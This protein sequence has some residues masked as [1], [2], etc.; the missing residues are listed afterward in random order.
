MEGRNVTRNRAS[1]KKAGATFE[2]IVADY[3][4]EHVDDRIDRRVRS[5]AKDKGDIAGVRFHGLRIVLEVKNHVR[6]DLAGWYAEA[7][8][9]AE[10]DGAL[11][12]AVIS[13]R[14]GTSDPGRSWVHMTL[15]DLALI[16]RNAQ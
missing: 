2:R 1:A 6:T 8:V 16:L 10:N 13:K 12:G 3:L 11:L 14:H 9:E 15:A 4:A 5:G 7:A